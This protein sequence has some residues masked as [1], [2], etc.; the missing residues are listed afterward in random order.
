MY[1]YRCGKDGTQQSVWQVVL[2]LGWIQNPNTSGGPNLG[3]VSDVTLPGSPGGAVY[4]DH[5]GGH[6]IKK[7]GL[8]CNDAMKIQPPKS[9]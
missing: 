6:N 5:Y 9:R 1:P 4:Q 8:S 2:C 3:S 7:N